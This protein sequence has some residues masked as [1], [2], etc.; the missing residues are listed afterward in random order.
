M[1]FI[2]LTAREMTPE[3]FNKV[4]YAVWN[5]YDGADNFE[6]L[7]IEGNCYESGHPKKLNGL[8]PVINHLN[9]SERGW[10]N[11]TWYYMGMGGGAVFVHNIILELYKKYLGIV[12]NCIEYGPDFEMAWKAFHE[13]WEYIGDDNVRYVL[14]KPGKNNL[15]VI[16][17]NPS[18]ATPLQLDPTIKKVIKISETN[19]YDGWIMVNLYPQ[20]STDPNGMIYNPQLVDENLK[21]IESVCK[22]YNIKDVWCAWGDLI[23][24]F[25]KNS[26]LHESWK[27]IETLLKKLNVNFYHYDTLTKNQ[28]PRHPLYVP[29]GRGFHKY[30]TP[31][32][33]TS[34]V[35]LNDNPLKG[36]LYGAILG[37]ILGAPYEFDKDVDGVK[38]TKNFIFFKGHRSKFTDD[39]VMTI[40]VA[41]ALLGVDKNADEKT[42]CDVIIKSMQKWGS[43]YPHAGYG[44]SFREWLK[45]NNPQPYKSYGNGSAMRVS[46]VGWL[47]DSIERTREVA[48]W[49]A[50]VTHNH[51][52]GIKG[53]ESVASAIFLARNGSTQAEIKNYIVENFGYDLNR[54]LDEIRPNYK[55]DTSC[56]GSYRKQ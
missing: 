37:D 10:G 17:V 33:Q 48:H 47:F 41:D 46:A 23:D 35:F 12:D 44:H 15:L 20:R 13:T 51:P 53:A 43:K 19:G 14:G 28:N 42:V 54:T 50:E 36:K 7:D 6:F 38:K 52:E 9:W 21:Q 56:Q 34:P 30:L 11:W 18:T 39:T 25:G 1:N 3:F 16:G 29:Y 8:F 31:V 26:F 32:I 45:E 24:T 40:A 4:F 27:N 55:F 49:T 2:P 22:K 5:T